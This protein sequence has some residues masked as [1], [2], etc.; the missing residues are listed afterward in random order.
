MQVIRDPAVRARIE[1]AFDLYEAAEQIM[2]Q[3]LRRRFPDASSEEIE[4]RLLDWLQ[5]RPGAGT[6][7]VR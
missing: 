3:N 1:T 5:K 6:A 2:R 7:Q 4:R